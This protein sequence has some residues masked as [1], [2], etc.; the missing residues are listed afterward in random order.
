LTPS[1]LLIIDKEE[2]P[3]SHDVVGSVRRVFG[4]RRVGHAGTLDPFATGVLV[5]L[6]GKATLLSQYLTQD[7]KKYEAEVL[8]GAATDTMDL[9]GTVVETTN[10]PMP[11][12]AE[13]ESALAAMIG[14]SMQLPPMY[15]AKKIDGRPLYKS[16]RLGVEVERKAHMVRIDELSLLQAEKD[17][18]RIALT[19]SKGTYVRAVA[20]SLARSLGGVGHLTALRRTKSGAFSIDQAVNLSSLLAVLPQNME[21]KQ[22]LL[23]RYLVPL[24]NA[25]PDLPAVFAREE[26][27]KMILNGVRPPLDAFDSSEIE[28]TGTV[29]V[30][31]TNKKLIAIARIEEGRDALTLVRV[32]DSNGA[33]NGT[34]P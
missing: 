10:R 17:R 11:S 9:T 21:E 31:D 28:K 24:E 14:T 1:G 25:L 22:T 29:R 19:C 6:A 4:L 7:V 26:I 16:A 30:L 2:G 34:K 32:L 12:R 8:W 23:S 13:I 20:D 18:F 15:S 3:T 33:G 27:K 5:V